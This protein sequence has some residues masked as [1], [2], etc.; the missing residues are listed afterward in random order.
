MRSDLRGCGHSDALVPSSHD[1]ILSVD[2]NGIVLTH[3]QV[4]VRASS[5]LSRSCSSLTS[6]TRPSM[7]PPKPTLQMLWEVT[8]RSET[9]DAMTIVVAHQCSA[10]GMA[11]LIVMVDKGRV[12]EAGSPG[13]DAPA[14]ACLRHDAHARRTPLGDVPART[15]LWCSEPRRVTI[16][17]G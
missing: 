12:L 9:S 4:R 11:A 10:V 13:T 8:Q 16:P 1:R 17:I 7:C 2:S 3:Q 14:R 5:C 15:A 6:R